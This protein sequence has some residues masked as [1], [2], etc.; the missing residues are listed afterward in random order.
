[1]IHFYVYSD[2]FFILGVAD[3]DLYAV[4]CWLKEELVASQG[5]SKTFLVQKGDKLSCRQK[6]SL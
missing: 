4:I 2:L 1:M 3:I 5:F 6:V